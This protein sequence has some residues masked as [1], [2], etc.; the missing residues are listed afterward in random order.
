MRVNKRTTNH[1]EYKRIKK[2]ILQEK[3]KI[4]EKID[5]LRQSTISIYVHQKGLNYVTVINKGSPYIE[6]ED[7]KNIKA[8]LITLYESKITQLNQ[9]LKAHE[10]L[11]NDSYYT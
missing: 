1:N 2:Q 6:K 10:I 8:F 11:F 4:A 7:V 3:K 9:K 5:L